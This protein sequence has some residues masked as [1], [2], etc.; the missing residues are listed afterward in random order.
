MESAA[1]VE[2]TSTSEPGPSTRWCETVE[3][4]ASA[5]Y[6]AAAESAV[7]SDS[8]ASIK[9]RPAPIE[10]A[11]SVEAME[12]GTRAN[13]H[14]PGKIIRPIVAVRRARVRRVPVVAVGAYRSGTDVAWPESNSNPD[15]RMGSSRPRYQ[16]EKPE[17]HSVL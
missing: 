12:P 15:L 6:G 16:H 13:K 1:S 9:C 10:S 2:V 14:A 4:T 7:K 8:A 11:P 3:P 5:R 17:H